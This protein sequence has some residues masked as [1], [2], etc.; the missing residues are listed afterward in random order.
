[1][2]AQAEFKYIH[3]KFIGEGLEY[4]RREQNPVDEPIIRYADVLLMWAEALVEKGDL[5][6]AM[7]KVKRSA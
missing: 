7:S 4:Q 1:M 5:S 3:R 6:G 2:N